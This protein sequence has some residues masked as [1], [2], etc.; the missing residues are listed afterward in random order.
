MRTLVLAWIA[1]PMTLATDYILAALATAFAVSLW[2]IARAPARRWAAA[3]VALA[4]GAFAGGTSHGFAP[5]LGPL[6]EAVL[7]KATVFAIGF[8]SFGMLAASAQ[9][10]LGPRAG[11]WTT[12]IAA[13]KLAIYLIWMAQHDDF[14]FVILDYAP[15]MAAVLAFNLYGWRRK[16]ISGSLAIA[17]GVIVSFAAAGVQQSGFALHRHFNHNDLYHVIQMI[18]LWLFYRG[19]SRQA[20]GPRSGPHGTIE[21]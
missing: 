21:T 19:A 2:R 18:G 4:V 9:A 3:L 15:N 12:A 11:R 6:G 1:E 7:W 5:H 10:T 20:L 16:R 14:K 13:V 17:A 8:A